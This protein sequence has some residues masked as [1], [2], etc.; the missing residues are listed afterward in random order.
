MTEAPSLPKR[1]VKP[2]EERRQE[3]V[4]SA[5]QLFKQKGFGETTVGDIA[6]AAGV[7]TGTVYLYFPSKD[8]VLLALHEQFHEGLAARIMEVVAD[9]LDRRSREEEVDF[10]DTINTIVDAMAAYS[11]ENKDYA[12]VCMK[13][14]PGSNFGSDLMK[15]DLSFVQFLAT[16]LHQAN[17]EGLIHTNDPDMM[18]HLLNGALSMPMGTWAAYND[19]PDLDRLLASAKELLQKALA[20]PEK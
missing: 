7:A 15:L 14:L 2:A 17:E 4:D 16:A 12:A 6:A 3:I 13:H 18:A 1:R 9:V 8:H 5:L 11:L 10:K 19:P 20:L